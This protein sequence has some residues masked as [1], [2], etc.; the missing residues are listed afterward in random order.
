MA[1][2]VGASDW[3]TALDWCA[4]VYRAAGCA[5]WVGPPA[6]SCRRGRFLAGRRGQRSDTRADAAGNRTGRAQ[7]ERRRR[8]LARRGCQPVLSRG[9]LFAQ[10]RRPRL[11]ACRMGRTARAMDRSI[12][13]PP[14]GRSVRRR[15]P[16][17]LRRVPRGGFRVGGRRRSRGDRR[18]ADCCSRQR[19]SHRCRLDQTEP[20]RHRQRRTHGLGRLQ[21]RRHHADRLRA[22]GRDRRRLHRASGRRLASADDQGRIDHPRRAHR[23]VERRNPHCRT[24][25]RTAQ[26]AH[27]RRATE[28]R[29]SCTC[30]SRSIASTSPPRST[31]AWRRAMRISPTWIRNRSTSFWPVRCSTTRAACAARC[32]SWKLTT[33]LRC[34]ASAKQI[35]I[36]KPDCSQSVTFH[37]FRKVLPKVKVIYNYAAGPEFAE[38]AR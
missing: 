21:E 23:E 12:R 25:A 15:R 2:P 5:G 16:R 8:D 9:S 10:G 35:P 31:C 28:D 33:L 4:R 22:F 6:R 30:N 27:C 11:R 17:A 20:V 32:S 34:V 37:G 38:V 26:F 1:L 13:G 29:S 24:T 7:A 18:D 19:R 14:G 36:G 3:Q